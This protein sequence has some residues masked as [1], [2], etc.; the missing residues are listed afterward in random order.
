MRAAVLKSQPLHQGV[1]YV[2]M[3]RVAYMDDAAL[4]EKVIV[5]GRSNLDAFLSSG[6]NLMIIA[7]HMNWEILAHMSRVLNI[8]FCVMADQRDDPR[9]E[10]LVND[11]R[12]RSGAT[13]LP[14]LL[15][16]C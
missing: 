6:R 12:V 16:M 5:E 14:P 4:K 8:P 13:I 15:W 9:L 3:I 10:G 2:D 1:L 11:L 7:G